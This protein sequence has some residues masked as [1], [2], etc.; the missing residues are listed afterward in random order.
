MSVALLWCVAGLGMVT[1]AETFRGQSQERTPRWNAGGGGDG[2]E[3]MALQLPLLAADERGCRKWMNRLLY[4]EWR[5][6]VVGAMQGGAS[7]MR[8]EAQTRWEGREARRLA[9][10]PTFMITQS[11][12][13]PKRSKCALRLSVVVTQFRP[14]TKIFPSC[15][16]IGLATSGPTI[17]PLQDVRARRST[18]CGAGM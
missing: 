14:P 5:G 2:K 13:A 9:G 17:P 6:R 15:P 4:W 16:P 11:D 18:R 10:R 7:P 3:T 12:I 1:G 8:F